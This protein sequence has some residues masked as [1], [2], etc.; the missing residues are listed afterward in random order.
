MKIPGDKKTPS[1]LQ[2][3]KFVLDPIEY[4]ESGQKK[5]GEIFQ[6]PISG[7]Y[8]PYILISNPQAIQQIFSKNSSCFDTVGSIYIKN[9]I[10]QNSVIAAEGKCHQRKRKILM[11]VFQGEDLYKYG[12]SIVLLT[13]KALNKLKKGQVVFAHSLMQQI[14]L[15]VIIEV[16]FGTQEKERIKQLKR[17]TTSWLEALNSP[18][19]SAAI[20][21]PSLQLDLGIWSPWGSYIRLKKQ[22]DRLIY[23]EITEKR[24]H[25]DSGNTDILSLLMKARDEEGQKMTDEE[26]HDEILGLLFAGHETSG[27]GLAWAMYWIHRNNGV[28]ERLLRELDNLENYFDSLSIYRLPYLTAVCNEALRMYPPLPKTITRIAN[29]SVKLMGYNLPSGTAVSGCIYLCH[30]REDLYP[31]PNKFKPER[32]L[33]K[34]F[35]SYEFM[36]FGGGTRSCIGQ[37]LAMLEMKIVL[38]IILS[39]YQLKLVENRSIQ[40]KLRAMTLVPS[41]GVKMLFKGQR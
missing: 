5:F 37:A 8:K 23:E 6:A 25:L 3:I 40:P 36:P 28:R 15:E 41:G 11:P 35:S 27:A 1:W 16:I 13:D 10:G 9:F 20:L 12:K 17:A 22:V 38:T 31:E 39:K 18:L 32:F 33:E 26:L 14:T 34:K 19:T 21:V 29:Q 7:S 2:K 30:R 24:Q 4:M